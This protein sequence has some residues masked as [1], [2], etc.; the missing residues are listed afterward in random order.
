MTTL[1]NILEQN[2]SSCLPDFFAI[3]FDSHINSEHHQVVL[4]TDASRTNLSYVSV[5]LAV[6]S[7]KHEM[8]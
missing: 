3:L 6:S 5:Y 4:A 8:A 2:I 7:V 1:A